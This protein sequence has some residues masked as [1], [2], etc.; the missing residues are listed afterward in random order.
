MDT[1]SGEDDYILEVTLMNKKRKWNGEEANTSSKGADNV[2]GTVILLC[3]HLWDIFVIIL[4]VRKLRLGGVF[5]QGNMY[6]KCPRLDSNT[7]CFHYIVL[8]VYAFSLCY[9]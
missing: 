2:L 1:F 8:V 6:K 4:Y 9:S 3:T 7:C 5:I